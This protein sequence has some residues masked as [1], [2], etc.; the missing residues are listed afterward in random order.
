MKKQH[1]FTALLAVTIAGFA[2]A[3]THA[4]RSSADVYVPGRNGGFVP[5]SSVIGEGQ[6][7]ESPDDHCSYLDSQGTMPNPADADKIWLYD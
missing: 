1:L 2:S 7:V 4:A 5:K 6:C 3:F